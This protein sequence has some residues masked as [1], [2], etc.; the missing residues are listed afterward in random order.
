[1]HQPDNFIKSNFRLYFLPYLLSFSFDN[2]NNQTNYL[3][4]YFLTPINIIAYIIPT[5]C[6]VLVY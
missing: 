5:I 2:P 4:E 3:Q 1:M 6:Y